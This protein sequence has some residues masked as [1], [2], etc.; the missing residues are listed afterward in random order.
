MD[1]FKWKIWFQAIRPHTLPASI[2]PSVVG[3]WLSLEYW[4]QQST[5]GDFP[6]S[7]GVACALF[8][9]FAQ[10]ACN[11]SNDYFDYKAGIDQ[12]GKSQKERLLLNGSLSPKKILIGALLFLCIG[13]LFGLYTILYAGFW[14]I[15]L[16]ILVTMGVFAYTAGPYPLAHHGFSELCVIIFYGLIAVGGTFYV[17]TGT[18][19]WK[20][21]FF[22]LGMGFATNNIMMVNNYRDRDV[23][24]AAGKVTLANRV[25]SKQFP[26]LYGVQGVL[27]VLCFAG[28]TL[29]EGKYGYLF[30]LLYLF[31]HYRLYRKIKKVNHNPDLNP[32]LAKT[33]VLCL[34]LA[35][36]VILGILSML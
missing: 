34:L 35:V 18:Y 6:I 36:L 21:F 22:G 7:A 23:D 32:L 8:A 25:G 9:L 11:L 27:A 13:C 15:P 33:S 3:I 29:V 16:G 5:K 14:V 31:P 20:V 24:R 4:Q 28:F 17:M 1:L 12:K 30:S 19:A 2:A 26:A 10:I